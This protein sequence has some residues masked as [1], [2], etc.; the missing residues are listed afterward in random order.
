M[1]ALAIQPVS[2]P[3]TQD[4]NMENDQARP[5]V[6]QDFPAGSPML[7]PPEERARLSTDQRCPRRRRRLVADEEEADN[8]GS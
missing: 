6:V 5:I 2:H 7:L 3:T 8:N 4:V 1:N